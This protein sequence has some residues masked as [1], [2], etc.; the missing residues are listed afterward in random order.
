VDS[1]AGSAA[2]VIVFT[3]EMTV[4]SNACANAPIPWSHDAGDVFGEMQVG[5]FPIRREFMPSHPRLKNAKKTGS[6]KTKHIQKS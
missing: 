2:W 4:L 6:N 1:T 5:V 3:S